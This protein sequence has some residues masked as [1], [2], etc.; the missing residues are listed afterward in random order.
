MSNKKE[1]KSDR[2]NG[3]IWSKRAQLI[4]ALALALVMAALQIASAFAQGAS[5]FG[6]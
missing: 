2:H 3:F 1:K 5:G 6:M 4:Y